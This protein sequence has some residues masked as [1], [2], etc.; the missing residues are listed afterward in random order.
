[1]I[2]EFHIEF[3]MVEAR[4]YNMLCLHDGIDY[5]GILYMWNYSFA[6]IALT[7]CRVQGLN[8]RSVSIHITVTP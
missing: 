4:L 2:T 8:T 1:M 7:S 5:Y 3:H 6:K